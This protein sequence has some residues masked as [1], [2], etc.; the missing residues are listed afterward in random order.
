MSTR[1]LI[2][3]SASILINGA[4]LV[5]LAATS[6]IPVPAPQPSVIDG[7]PVTNLPG[8][9]VRPAE[10]STIDGLSVTDLPGVTVRPSAQ[11]VA[12][13]LSYPAAAD[14]VAGTDGSRSWLHGVTVQ[15]AS[16]HLRMPYYSFASTSLQIGKE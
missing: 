6:Q 2:A 7:L 16:P 5:A 8:I 10:S 4:G 13:A 14:D 15:L 3:L 12:S 11:A 9:I 1:K